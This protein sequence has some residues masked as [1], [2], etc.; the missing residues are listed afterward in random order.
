MKKLKSKKG[1]M[2]FRFSTKFSTR[3]F[4]NCYYHFVKI[5]CYLI[6]FQ[7]VAYFEKGYEQ[8]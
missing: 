1:K 8:S 7:P 4:L 3:S 6:V 5:I 2:A